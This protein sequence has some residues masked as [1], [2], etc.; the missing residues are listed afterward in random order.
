[1]NNSQQSH[2]ISHELKQIKGANT[3][4]MHNVWKKNDTKHS[5]E[6]KALRAIKTNESIR[7]F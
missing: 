3:R 6:I 5:N 2:T 4:I 7:I 1:M